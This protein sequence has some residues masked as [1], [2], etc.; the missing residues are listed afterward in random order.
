LWQDRKGF[1]VIEATAA[2]TRTRT[3]GV[4]ALVALGGAVIVALATGVSSAAPAP[5]APNVPYDL[6][7]TLPGLKSS[8][9]V[10][11]SA[12]YTPAVLSLIAQLEGSNPPTQAQ[13]RTQIC[14]CTRRR[15]TLPA[16]GR[17]ARP[18]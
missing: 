16:A 8:P 7:V 2:E 18:P 14:C 9:P 15:R 4:R 11:A 6:P 1:E 3:H 12:P 10:D 17:L 5:A 13:P